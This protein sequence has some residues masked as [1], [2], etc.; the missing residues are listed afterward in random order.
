MGGSA[1]AAPAS[2]LM[3]RRGGQQLVIVPASGLWVDANFKE[4]QLARMQEGTP[5]EIRADILPDKVFPRPCFESG[6]SDGRAVQRAAAGERDGQLHQ[7]CAARTRAHRPGPKGRDARP[8]ASGTFPS[9]SR[10]TPAAAR[11]RVRCECGRT[12]ACRTGHSGRAKR[13]AEGICLRKHVLGMFIALLD[14]QIVSAF[15]ARHRAALFR[16]VRTKTVWVQ[17]SY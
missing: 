13:C 9:P 7:E 1:I 8:A 5:V 2:A 16:P 17:T 10:S 12:A 11:A 15:A 14:I 3:R 6:A 4:G